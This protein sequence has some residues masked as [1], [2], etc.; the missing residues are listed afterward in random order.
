[1]GTLHEDD[2]L[3]LTKHYVVAVKTAA[4]QAKSADADWEESAQADFARLG[5]VLTA[6]LRT[7][8]LQSA[9][10]K[11]SQIHGSDSLWMGG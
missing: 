2:Q 3:H 10:A 1:M 11:A 7:L 8:I 9:V 6:S 4:T 5:A